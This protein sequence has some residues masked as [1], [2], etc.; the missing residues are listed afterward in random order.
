MRSFLGFVF[1]AVVVAIVAIWWFKFER[2][3]PTAALVAPVEVLGRKTPFDVRVDSGSVALRSAS[4]RL[5]PTQGEQKDQAFELA[6][7]TYPP[8]SWSDGGVS[9]RQFHVETD[10]VELGV[11]EGPA[12][13]EVFVDTY[14]WHLWASAAA[15]RL[16]VP[17]QV[18]LSP[19]RI[20][21]LSSQ[22]NLRLGG[23]DLAVF[24]QS[25]DTVRSGIAVG[26]YF[27]PST[28]GYFADDAVALALFAAPQDLTGEIRFDVVAEDAAGNQRRVQL[29]ARVKR[30]KFEER[31]LNVDDNFLE[32]KVPDILEANNMRPPGNLVEQY[33]YVNRELRRM[34][35][36]QIREITATS[37]PM[38]LWDG[39]F[40][41]QPNAASLSTFGDRRT[42][43][44]KDEVIDHQ[45]HL[46]FDLASLKLSPVAASQN[47]V[48]VFADNLGIYGNAVILDHGLG[49]FSLYGH[50]STLAVAKDERVTAGQSVG[51]TGETGLAGGDHL[52]FSIMLNGLHV[53]PIEWWDP[54]WI[55]DH[56]T[57]RLQLSPRAGETKTEASP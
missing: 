45:V 52:H 12:I 34:N 56:V 25:P 35:E 1:V 49:L 20:E 53:D 5:R 24:R 50:L 16:E 46:G 47:G 30:R 23:V 48:V 22:H 6:I 44:Y 37:A 15:P 14:A 39:A 40:R 17:V 3:T 13:L 29:P 38:P 42:Y 31:T 8:A 32:R 57:A 41:R 7:E 51:Q 36:A 11:P 26:D 27:F 28:R 2:Q 19:P 10:L 18:D 54:H 55:K 21:I 43:K 33:L 4:V 9:E